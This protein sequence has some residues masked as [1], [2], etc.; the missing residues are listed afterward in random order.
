MNIL[1]KQYIKAQERKGIQFS[2]ARAFWKAKRKVLD[3]KKAKYE[4]K[5]IVYPDYFTDK[6]HTYKDGHLNWDHAYQTH[7]H[8]QGS[9][10]MSMKD[11]MGTTKFTP[12]EAY[13]HYKNYILKNI[14]SV[15]PKDI[16]YLADLGCGTCETTSLLANKFSD[17]Y[18]AGI[19]L[20][21]NYL[22]IADYNYSNLPN[23]Q[24]FHANMEDVPFESN[25]FDA[26]TICYAF[27]EMI[28]MA[29]ENSLLEAKRILKPHGTLVILDM[30][31]EKLPKYPDFIDFSEPHLQNYRSV[32]ILQ[33]LNYFG[34]I[35]CNKRDLHNYSSMFYAQK[36]PK[37]H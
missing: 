23:T 5:T 1:T 15:F 21:P 17:S 3:V 29:I 6:I 4:N 27:H 25:F 28:P 34:Y 22:S 24:L 26:V 32:K 37:E 8:M 36:S 18:I 16:K 30:D 2:K 10:L 7:C 13:V 19:D 12:E 35:N 14:M 9:A 20:S 11:I 31:P 33:L